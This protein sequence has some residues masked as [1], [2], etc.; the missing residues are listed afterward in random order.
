MLPVW[1]LNVTHNNKKYQFAVNGQT[2]KVTGK[3]PLNYGLVAGLSVLTFVLAYAL[4]A[5]LSA[6]P[7]SPLGLG[8]GVVATAIALF[9]MYKSHNKNNVV[10]KASSYFVGGQANILSKN[11]RY[12]RTYETKVPINN[13][14]NKKK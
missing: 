11:A 1:L 12:I 7:V 13:N 5:L 14:N 3:L 6:S 8:A 9:A 4:G 2:G 10:E